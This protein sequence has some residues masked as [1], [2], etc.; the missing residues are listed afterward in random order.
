MVW[1]ELPVV[2][3]DPGEGLT[4]NAS[5]IELACMSRGVEQVGP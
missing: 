3:K 2:H 1:I 4:S 5:V